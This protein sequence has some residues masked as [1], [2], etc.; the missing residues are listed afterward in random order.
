MLIPGVP[1]TGPDAVNTSVFAGPWTGFRSGTVVFDE[2][3]PT[4]GTRSRM[5]W[6]DSR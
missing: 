3:P 1:G 6:T 5:A 4:P 2:P